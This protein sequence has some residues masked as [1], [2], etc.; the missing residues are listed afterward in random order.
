L[1]F[2]SGEILFDP[3]FQYP[4]TDQVCDKYLLIL[5]KKHAHSQNVV[6][7]PATTN[8]HLIPYDAGCND[9]LKIFYFDKTG[10]FFQM[11]TIIQLD[12]VMIKDIDWL[13]ELIEKKGILRESKK[14]NKIEFSQ[15]INCLKKIR[16]DIAL[17]IQELV[18]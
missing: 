7:V 1:E 10:S 13:E 18:F 2:Y 17:D 12:Y 16:E 11:G 9:D 5:N 4:H 14:I 15:I 8:K 6:I 3:H